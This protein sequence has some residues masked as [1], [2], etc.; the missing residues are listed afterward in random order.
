MNAGLLGWC[1]STRFTM[2]N[3]PGREIFDEQVNNLGIVFLDDYIDNIIASQHRDPLIELVKTPGRNKPPQPNK[4]VASST[5]RTAVTYSLEDD[6][7]FV[8]NVLPVNAFTEKLLHAQDNPVHAQDN[9][10][11][12]MPLSPPPRS[13]PQP[14]EPPASEQKELFVITEDDETE[15]S[16]VS[17]HTANASSDPVPATQ[18]PPPTTIVQSPLHPA[19]S[20]GPPTRIQSPSPDVNNNVVAEHADVDTDMTD[21]IPLPSIEPPDSPPKGLARKP[22]IPALPSLPMFRKSIRVPS[23]SAVP[24]QTGPPSRTSWL[25]KAREV[26][27]RDA[28]MTIKKPLPIPP[29][30]PA[31][32][33]KSGDMLGLDSAA[34]IEDEERPAKSTKV[35]EEHTAPAQSKPT[36][37]EDQ[38]IEEP[39][40]DDPLGQL[41]KNLDAARWGKSLG[42]SL[43]GD[44]ANALAQA[45]AAA[46]A[47]VAMQYHHE[48]APAALSSPPA[49]A[50]HRLSI[51]ELV[52]SS[53]SK[54]KASIVSPSVPEPTTEHEPE[55]PVVSPSPPVF[56]P[57]STTV[58]NKPV[59]APPKTSPATF[60]VPMTNPF[61]RPTVASVGLGTRLPSPK[62]S[63]KVPKT[64]ALSAQ[65]TLESAASDTLFDSHDVPAWMPS[66][67]D[68]EY[69]SGFGS[70]SQCLLPGATVDNFDDDDSWPLQERLAATSTWLAN[71]KDDSMTWST[72]PTSSTRGDTGPIPPPVPD[73]DMDTG[74]IDEQDES[75]RHDSQPIPGSFHMDVD[76]SDDAQS[77]DDVLDEA[78]IAPGKSTV[79]LVEPNA[80]RSQSQMSQAST[81]SSQSQVGFFGQAT[82]LVN[83]I[84]G[85]S[86]KGKTE[87]KSIQLAAAAA[88]KAQEENEKK[89]NRLKEMENRRQ[90]LLQRKAEEEKA[91]ALEEERKLKEENERRKKER[92]ELTDK[93]PL[94]KSV[95]A[96]KIPIEAD[97]KPELKKAPSK[98]NLNASSSSKLP[99]KS[100]IGKPPQSALAS[101]TTFN[102]S[103]TVESSK[104]LT[105]VA[106]GKMKVD[107]DASQP[108]QIL[109]SQMAA[110]AKAQLQAANLVPAT[111][112][113]SESIEL[114]DINSEYSDSDD[115]DRP[116]TFNPPSWAQSPDLR[117]A[118]EMQSTINPDDI[119]GAIRPLK[120]EEVFRNRSGRF[121]A[122]T[123]S[124]NWTG[125]DKLTLEEQRDY[126]RRMGYKASERP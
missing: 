5:L 84:L 22:S 34:T 11:P 49:A 20:T 97:K 91:K 56:H 83:N 90:A 51:S 69:T 40:G 42:K 79:S 108:A 87:V 15:R 62:T 77:L 76:D 30:T 32:K 124:A 85:S 60:K 27:T 61:S 111:P 58:F 9:A 82:K 75:V 38:A 4:P 117:Q 104:S 31:H 64:A 73:K 36:P 78:D 74:F 39:L 23:D 14:S 126:V 63:P 65:S 71:A 105:F 37:S 68:T 57:P 125:N 29:V 50:H 17:F 81:S 8:Q 98:P 118:L 101:S 21:A 93:R 67:Q 41:K 122:R 52:T 45:R 24:A 13:P 120:M 95:I 119:F 18:E 35:S 88:K 103:K 92:E 114:P 113:P 33:R 19:E 96:K 109:Q 12:A 89:A 28:P 1:N 53:E 110:R 43:G 10:A 106:K 100:T 80:A 121:R 44:A 59:F 107:D 115:E 70:Q 2:A 116:R 26:K 123:S 54:K 94:L 102:A 86:K 25:M 47:K 46:E 55:P 112:I 6:S 66:T 72:L 3:D 16:R 99:T 48:E 7:P